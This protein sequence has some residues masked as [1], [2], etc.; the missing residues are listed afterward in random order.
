MSTAGCRQAAQR[1]GTTPGEARDRSD[2]FLGEIASRFTNVSRTPRF[3]AARG[4]LGKYSLTPSKL[5]NDT[6]VW[7]G[8]L[9]DG[10]RTLF[11]AGTSTAGGYVF[12]ARSALPLPAVTGD[13]RHWMRL[14]PRGD[15][16]YHWQTSVDQAV[17]RMPAEAVFDAFGGL[18]LA[19]EILGERELRGDYRQYFP[20]T[21]AALGRLF[22]L[23]TVRSIAHREGGHVVTMSIG[24]HPDRLRATMPAFA[25]YVEKYVGPARYRFV[26]RDRGPSGVR[27][28]EL[29]AGDDRLTLRFRTQHGRLLPFE[30]PPRAMP[31]LLHLDGELFAKVMIFE[32]GASEI[33]ADVQRLRTPTEQAWHFR[34]QR[35]PEWQLPLA[36]KHL[37]RAPLRRPFEQGGAT[38]QIGFRESTPQ[39]TH[40]SREMSIVV[41]ES[42]ILRWLGALGWTA[43][44]DFAGASEREEN[45]FIA[46]AFRAMQ[47]DIRDLGLGRRD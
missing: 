47:A 14:R 25:K 35:E 33:A 15:S 37:I 27:W 44:S 31:E 16:E 40:L 7:T 38:F 30:G 13:S 41:K 39:V 45:R 32:V 4:R 2:A 3:A 18:M 22:S 24:L 36:S 17:G 28:L 10:T 11:T 46:E 1:F 12:D 20:R 43:M 29:G 26:L 6:S 19:A 23:D 5:V 42:A 21:T 34:F 9:A 8:Q